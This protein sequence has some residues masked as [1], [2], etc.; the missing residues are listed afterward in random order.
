ML[1]LVV[2]R[3][4]ARFQKVNMLATVASV[5][6]TR[7][8]LCSVYLISNRFVIHVSCTSLAYASA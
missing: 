6:L 7:I 8:I 2:R 4:V 5:S 1:N 3:V